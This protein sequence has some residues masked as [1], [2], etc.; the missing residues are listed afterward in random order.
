MLPVEPKRTT[1]VQHEQPKPFDERF[2][3]DAAEQLA[4]GRGVAHNASLD[5]LSKPWAARYAAST[6][7]AVDAVLALHV[8]R[9]VV[10]RL[11]HPQ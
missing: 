11:D 5:A 1:K 9:F 6:P 2:I 4:H 8:G 3:L 10:V 7:T